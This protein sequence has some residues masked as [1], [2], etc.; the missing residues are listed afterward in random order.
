MGGA[1]VGPYT[2]S[3]NGQHM[4]VICDDALNEVFNGET[5]IAASSTMAGGL[6]QAKWKGVTLNKGV[7]GNPSKEVLTQVQEYQAI[8]YLSHLMMANLS[9]PTM[10]GELQWAIWDL[11]TPGL[12]NQSNGN[13]AWGNLSPYL[14]AI[15]G[16]IMAGINHDAGNGSQMVIYTPT[17]R[18]VC[19]ALR[20]GMP[21]EYIQ[22]TPEPASLV[23]LATGLLGV[24]AG[25]RKQKLSA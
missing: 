25:L 22:V 10:V 19:R 12:I 2:I 3:V 16:D 9:N 15:D 17:D 1:Y 8:Q 5:W 24:G 4:M 7:D 21:Q 11:T 14:S 23:L 20:C 13:E 6:E 18:G